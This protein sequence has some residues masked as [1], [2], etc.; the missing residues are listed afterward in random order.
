MLTDSASGPTSE[1]MRV[2]RQVAPLGVAVIRVG[3]RLDSPTNGEQ[4]VSSPPG[5]S[6][7]ARRAQVALLRH[8]SCGVTMRATE[9]Y[10]NRNSKGDVRIFRKAKRNQ[11][12]TITL[13]DGRQIT[14]DRDWSA[15]TI[16]ELAAWG[17][18]PGMGADTGMEI[19]VMVSPRD[20]RWTR[21][22]RPLRLK[23]R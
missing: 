5:V 10:R 2:C 16:E 21:R 6:G 20:P 12:E 15:Y 13:P 7:R 11:G 22:I 1:K 3:Q 23:R 9:L 8:Q 17:I 19:V 14:L 4:P 18:T